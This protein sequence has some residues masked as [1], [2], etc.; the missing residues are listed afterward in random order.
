[1]GAWRPLARPVDF[2]AALTPPR[3]PG[4]R[5]TGGGH[6]GDAQVHA[7]HGEGRALKP[8]VQCAIVVGVDMRLFDTDIYTIKGI[9]RVRWRGRQ[10][11]VLGQFVLLPD[12]PASRVCHVVL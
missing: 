5:R 2:E 11:L 4:S 8:F 9:V 12:L 6:G 7:A 3:S 1:M 10:L